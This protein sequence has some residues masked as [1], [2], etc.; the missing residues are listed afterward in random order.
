M[1]E[2]R[3]HSLAWWFLEAES[4]LRIDDEMSNL[5]K[6]SLKPGSLYI[7]DTFLRIFFSPHSTECMGYDAVVRATML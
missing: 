2:L 6:Q 3:S 1:A 5:L 7:F 4:L